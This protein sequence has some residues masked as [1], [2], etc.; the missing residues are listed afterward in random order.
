MTHS[1]GQI[2][3]FDEVSTTRSTVVQ[4]AKAAGHAKSLNERPSKA[5]PHCFCDYRFRGYT[6]L[7]EAFVNDFLPVES[8]PMTET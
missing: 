7:E 4:H 3:D 8:D 1:L 5:A 2:D 6:S